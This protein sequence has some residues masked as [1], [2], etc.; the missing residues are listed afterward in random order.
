M[1]Y[2]HH[3]MTDFIVCLGYKGYVIKEYFANYFMHRSDTKI[4]L[5]TGRIDY[6]VARRLPRWTVTLVDT[7]AETMTGGR[8]KRIG[9][10]L[11]KHEPFCM[12]YGDGVSDIDLTALMTFHKR[13]GLLG[14]LTAVRPPS[15]YGVTLVA[16]E[17][18]VS[19]AE[20]PIGEGG[21]INAGFFVLEPGVLDRVAGDS[22]AWEAY[23]LESLAADGQLGAYCHEG[24]WHPMDTLRD[25]NY[26]EGLWQ[27]G[28]APWRAWDREAE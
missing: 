8:V 21:R 12:T 7:G 6:I 18:V 1:Q 15:R 23:P 28:K 14:T 26:L 24:F 25:K 11:N 9:H 5:S 20:K 27:S 22:T 16:G 3:G 19:F 10:L 17:K 13:N 2:A 4:D